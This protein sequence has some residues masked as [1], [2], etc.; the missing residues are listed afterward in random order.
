MKKAIGI[1]IAL[2]VGILTIVISAGLERSG[3][4]G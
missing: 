4:M 2:I 1:I 3:L